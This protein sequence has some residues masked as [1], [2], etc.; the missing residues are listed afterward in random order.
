MNEILPKAQVQRMRNLLGQ[1][2]RGPG[3][4]HPSGNACCRVLDFALE[5]LDFKERKGESERERV[6]FIDNQQV[7]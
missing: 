3:H 2:V 1:V 6:E 4:L 7:T 5:V